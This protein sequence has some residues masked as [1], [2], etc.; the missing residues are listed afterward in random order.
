[1]IHH[2]WSPKGWSNSKLIL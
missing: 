1:M 2:W